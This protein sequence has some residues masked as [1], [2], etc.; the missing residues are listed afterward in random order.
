MLHPKPKRLKV[1]KAA[2]TWANRHEKLNTGKYPDDWVDCIVKGEIIKTYP[3]W[4]DEPVKEK[5]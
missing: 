2:I 1:K 4:Y 5:K 3:L